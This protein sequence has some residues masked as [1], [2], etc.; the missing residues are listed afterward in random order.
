MV[1]EGFYNPTDPCHPL[2][3]FD[4]D[5]LR[6]QCKSKLALVRL[7]KE[8]QDASTTEALDHTSELISLRKASGS[9]E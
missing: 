5:A 2:R 9:P 6:E 7:P 3:W 1:V 4:R 8:E